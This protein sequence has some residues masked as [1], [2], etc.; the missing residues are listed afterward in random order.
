MYK[1]QLKDAALAIQEAAV[2]I[3][4]ARPPLRQRIVNAPSNL[5]LL[6]HQWYGDYR[7]AGELARLNPQV[8]NPNDIDTGDILNGYSQ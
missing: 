5:H 3:I 7:R 1:R 4:E 2:V 6:A 8:R